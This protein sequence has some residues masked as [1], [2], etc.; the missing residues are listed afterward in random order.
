MR[1]F[2]VKVVFKNDEVTYYTTKGVDGYH[3]MNK[4]RIALKHVGDIK[5]MWASKVSVAQ[6][7]LIL[8]KKRKRK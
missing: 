2:K 8:T 1:T 4:A 3:A 5:T 6:A 7:R